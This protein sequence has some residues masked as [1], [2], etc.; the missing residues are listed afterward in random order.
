MSDHQSNSV[1]IQITA[2]QSAEIDF[3]SHRL[4][5]MDRRLRTLEVINAKLLRVVDQLAGDIADLQS[6]SLTLV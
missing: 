1:A 5:Q 4:E 3:L 2:E 6:T